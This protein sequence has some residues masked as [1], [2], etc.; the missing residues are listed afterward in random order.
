MSTSLIQINSLGYK[1]LHVSRKRNAFND[2]RLENV[3]L[4]YLKRLMQHASTNMELVAKTDAEIVAFRRFLQNERVATDELIFHSCDIPEKSVFGEQLVVYGDTTSYNLKMKLAQIRDRDKI[5]C[6][7]DNRTAGFHSHV[8]LVANRKTGNLLGLSDIQLWSRPQVKIG[9]T[10]KERERLPFEEKESAKWS[11]GVRN[12]MRLLKGADVLFIF[13]SE[14]DV[15]ENFEHILKNEG[16]GF[17]IRSRYN[18]RTNYLGQKMHLQEVLDLSQT[19][20]CYTINLPKLT[21]R[22]KRDKPVKRSKRRARMELKVIEVEVVPPVRFKGKKPIKLRLIEAKEVSAKLPKGEK[23]IK[24]HLWTTEAISTFEEAKEIVKLYGWRW[25]IE[26][27]FRLTKKKGYGMESTNLE[28][29]DAILK[30]TVMVL[31]SAS[32]VLQLLKARE[33]DESQK[34]EEVF[35]ETE[36]R[37]LEKLNIHLQGKT[38]LLKNK[39]KKDRLS[40]AAWIIARL[41]GWKG[42]TSRGLPGPIIYTRGVEEFLIFVEASKVLS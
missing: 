24:W 38:E 15:Y 21:Y 3:R 28:S 1:N 10:N 36:I 4:T 16:A 27:L 18:R 14:A 9:K 22:F 17:I 39:N 2:K 8:N 42:Y 32:L 5:G 30:Q 20:G 13:D 12:S 6:L 25:N 23:P 37:V 29:F 11:R 40:W 41:G 26:Q 7:D 31:K 35:N 19:L 33:N 34:I